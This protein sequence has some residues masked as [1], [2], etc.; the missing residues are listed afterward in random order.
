MCK[1]CNYEGEELKCGPH[2]DPLLQT[3]SNPTRRE[4]PQIFKN[5]HWDEDKV[6]Q[7]GL[8]C[9]GTLER[10]WPAFL[11]PVVVENRGRNVYNE[12]RVI[13]LP[14]KTTSVPTPVLGFYITMT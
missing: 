9:N 14:I 3:L 1:L 6:I 8:L 12:N 11:T 4:I 10:N 2:T 5:V 13:L 7:S